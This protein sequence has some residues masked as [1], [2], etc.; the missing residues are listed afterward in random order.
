MY[1]ARAKEWNE[2]AKAFENYVKTVENAGESGIIKMKEFHSKADPMYEVMGSAFE[3]NSKE[4]QQIIDTLKEWGVK[5]NYGSSTLGYGCTCRGK[6]GTMSITKEA[7]YSA[8]CHEFQHI[9]D[10]KEAGWDGLN[11]LWFDHKERE[12]RE[13]R[14]YDIEIQL[15]REAGRED[16]V[17]RLEENLDEEVRKIYSELKR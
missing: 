3:S 10:D 17:K 11:V 4:V 15:A 8:W 14:A 6:P 1:G 13:R 16:I 2:K 7:S 5:V 12:R 9:K